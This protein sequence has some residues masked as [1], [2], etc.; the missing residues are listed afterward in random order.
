M[1]GEWE[2]SFERIQRGAQLFFEKSVAV[3]D[4]R[5]AIVSGV[6]AA[7]ARMML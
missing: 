3:I 7:V 1:R 5:T 4:P 6:R 2:R